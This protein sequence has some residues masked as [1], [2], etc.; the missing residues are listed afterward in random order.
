[1]SARNLH[2]LF[3]PGSIAVIG[4][5]D[6]PG[7]VGRVVLGNLLRAGFSGPI[8][9]V[10]R[11]RR[12]VGGVWAYPDIESLPDTPDLAVICTPAA[13]VPEIIAALGRRGTRAAL[14]LN[15][16]YDQPVAPGGPLLG[17]LVRAAAAPYGLRILGGDSL[18]VLVPRHALDAS[19]SHVPAQPGKIAFVSQSGAFSAA[20][21]DW[22]AA[23]GIGFSHFIS[24]GGCI[25]V[26]FGDVL[27]YLAGD[28]E[29][30]A[31]LLYVE[32]IR[33][34]GSFLS[35]GRSAARNKPVLV[36]KVD[37]VREE[38]DVAAATLA[39]GALAT[40]DE[41]FDA[42]V[43]RA[44]MLRVDDIDEL[45]AAVETLAR[46]RPPVGDR[47]AIVTNGGGAGAV[48]VDALL[49][50]GG[51]LAHFSDDTLTKLRGQVPAVV[52]CGN[53][54]DIRLAADGQRYAAVLETLIDAPEA[55]AVLVVH[56]P[57]ALVPAEQPAEAVVETVKDLGGHVFASWIGEAGVIQA[58]KALTAAGIPSYD[59]PIRAVR[60]FLHMVNYRRNQA[61]LMQ[62]PPS[63]L[64]DFRPA[65]GMARLV[66]EAV[67]AQGREVLS[68]PEAKAI[69]TAY[70]LP[71]I[72]THVAADAAEA[73]YIA[74]RIGF[75]VAVTVVAP[76]V[77]RKWDVGGVALNLE[78]ADAVHTA[79]LGMEARLAARRP[80]VRL[81]G[82]TVQRMVSRHNARQLIIGVATDAVFGPVI[83]FGEG[84]RAVEIIRDHAIGLPP[85][86][87][88]LAREL[89]GRTRISRLLSAYLDRPAA[90]VDAICETLMK[91]SQ[92][93]VDLPELVEVDI[94]PLFADD[95]G[96]TVVDAHMRVARYRGRPQDRLA[97]RPYP[98]A[99]E[100]QAVLRDGRAVLL[101]PIRPEDEPA[102]QVLISH[103]TPEDLRMRFFG[104][105]LRRDQVA[106]F[107]QIDYDR[108][109]AFIATVTD[110]A[111]Q[112]ETL[113]VVRAVRDAD[114][115]RAEFAVVVR[116]DLKGQGLGPLLIDKM[117]GYLRAQGVKVM[118]G[119]V[120]AENYAM[121]ALA[122]KM[123][124]RERPGAESGVVEV[125]RE[126]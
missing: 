33:Q 58:R 90:N 109:M 118:S 18:G 26:D 119:E 3:A 69:L 68:E 93:V 92:M 73:A 85:L 94:N 17:G 9:P 4:A 97:I 76:E 112:A 96:V 23:R 25:D 70:G 49:S 105:R 123:G 82:F 108:E 54:L 110:A 91:V 86:N 116:P 89:V 5:T 75:P 74:E 12:S 72:V 8:F 103:M 64:E 50:G 81:E 111:G 20:V 7:H 15:S 37:R 19:F 115:Q 41:V 59:S 78:S 1:M 120:L 34:R 56:S 98:K 122:A 40:P 117:I 65:E 87:M 113:G 44:G 2:A 36:V 13:P 95:R 51:H 53:P 107:T 46:A 61:L 48:A 52:A 35:A 55:D 39:S 28:T 14:L 101:R 22:A 11:S 102:H 21:L 63:A 77:T 124:C 24:L 30:R 99:L 114:N 31:I 38:E 29:T 43:R 27:D 60:A 71:V 16:G 80:G 126:V 42:A 100:E 83:L 62:T 47:L 66:I 79:A 121:L 6:R 88:V 104:G 125:W 10:N 67:L 57:N 84:G 106:R 45:F 32:E